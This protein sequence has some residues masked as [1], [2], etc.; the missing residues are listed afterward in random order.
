M[1]V[2]SH[3]EAL[4]EAKQALVSFTSL[5]QLTYTLNNSYELV[6]HVLTRVYW[7]FAVNQASRLQL[8]P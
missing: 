8:C 3:Y 4:H 2:I 6:N 7:D 1:L 5:F